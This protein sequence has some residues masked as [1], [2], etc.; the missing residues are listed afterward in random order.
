MADPRVGLKKSSTGAV[1]GIALTPDTAQF[2]APSHFP[3]TEVARQG[4]TFSVCTAA[5]GMDP[6]TALTTAPPLTLYNPVGSPG[7]LAIVR[8]G[9]GYVSGTLGAGMLVLAAIPH[10]Q[11]GAPTGGILL[12]PQCTFI[13]VSGNRAQAFQGAT[14]VSIPELVKPL[15]PLPLG[16]KTEEVLDGTYLVAPGC[17]VSLAVM[18]AAGTTPLVV[19]YLVWEFL[20][21]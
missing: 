15:L 17:S 16:G 11:Q 12:V 5:A 13:G 18:A 9:L 1:E 10:L 2:V 4:Q 19:V 20:L 6:G 8:A 7:A 3:Y 14:L 21:L